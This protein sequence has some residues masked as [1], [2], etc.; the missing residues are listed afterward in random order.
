MNPQVITLIDLLARQAEANPSRVA[1][2]CGGESMSYGE[3]ACRAEQV[4][5][6][7][8]A[9]GVARGDRV[10][11][12]LH[13]SFEE[14]VA[15]FAAWRLG[16]VMVNINQQWTYQ[17]LCYVIED[18]GI[19]ALL[20][21]SRPAGRVAEE[22][23]PAP[24]RRLLVKGKTPGHESMKA[25]EDLEQGAPKEAAPG[26]DADLAAILYTSGSTGSPKGVML[27]HQNLLT[28]A[29]SVC[30]YL[31]LRDDDRLLSLLPFS[32]D[33]GLN[34]LLDM[35]L[36]GGTTVLQPVAM[37]SVVVKSLVD[38][39]ITGFA[40]V[41]P[42]WIQT[43]RYLEEVGTSLPD[44]RLMTNSGGKVPDPILDAMPTVFPG[45]DIFLMYGLTEAFR[46]TYLP[47]ELFE[48]KRGSM[49][50]DI[51]NVETFVIQEDRICGPGEQGELVHRGSLVSMGYWGRPE[52]TAE[53]IR[54]CPALRDRIGEEKVVYSGDIVRIDEDG[55][56]WFVS[57]ADTM[58]KSS[59][60]RLSPTEVEEILYKSDQVME[61]VAFGVEDDLLGQAV[62]VAVAAAD[63]ESFREKELQTH[64]RQ[65]MPHYM[66]PKQIHLWEGTMP[67]TASGKI[68]TPS[69]VRHCKE[70]HA[71]AAAGKLNPGVQMTTADDLIAFIKE[72]REIEVSP[73]SILFSDGTI[74]SLGMVEIIGHLEEKNDVE[75]SQEDVTLENFDTVERIIAYV[76]SR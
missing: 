55:Y 44:L 74:D 73:D 31:G 29:R 52:A 8:E 37:P 57:R 51:P 47:P 11:V 19:E 21:D 1:L 48:A 15:M 50:S 58:I 54:S 41:P 66:Q 4:A 68:D 20:I 60:F 17:Q 28:G 70:R 26:I 14:V 45:V 12:H 62:H 13:K 64:C 23:L 2:R 27:S 7:L 9:E 75:V 5:A 34:Q 39:R 56:Y 32:F 53:K 3:L 65:Q 25:W 76:A 6:W 69:V 67:R 36:L 61:A 16:A 10:G 30:S 46:S 59:G 43:V 72:L 22:G 49:G 35:C 33:Y 63:P 18:A 24:L 40:A 71:D 42:V 38:E